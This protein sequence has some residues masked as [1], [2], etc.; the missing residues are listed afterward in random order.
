MDQDIPSPTRLTLTCFRPCPPA[1]AA[2][3]P[4]CHD[5]RGLRLGGAA[6][7]SFKRFADCLI[8]LGMALILAGCGARSN[9]SR[10]PVTGTVAFPNGEKFNGSISFVPAEGRAGPAATAAI[11]DGTYRFD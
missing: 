9:A 8:V 6:I 7:L 11:V 5:D 1:P 3:K 4:V 10:L 2:N